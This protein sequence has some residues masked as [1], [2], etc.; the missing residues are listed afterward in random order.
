MAER[1]GRS[2]I[3]ACILVGLGTFLLAVALLIPAYTVGKLK[4]TPLDLEVTTVATGNGDVLDSK[5]LLAG[6]A[7]VN[8]NVPIVAQRYVITEQ[9]SDAEVIS[10]QAGQTVRRTD[11]QGETGLLAATVDRLTADRVSAMPVEPPVGTI[12]TSSLVPAEEVSHTGLQ[13]KWPFDAEK[14]SYP[15][16]DLNTR[17]SNDINFV[18]ETEI[19]GMKVYHYNQTVEP[20][21]LSKVVP[22]DPTNK[23]TLPA[24]TWGVPGE[25]QPITMSRWYTNVRDVWVDPITGVVINGQEQLYQYYARDKAKPEVTVLKVTLPFDENTIE[26]QIGQAKD[27]Q[28][29][30]SLFGRTLPIVA[31]ILGVIALIAGLVI[32]IRGG[33]GKKGAPEGGPENPPNGS[34]QAE[35]HDWTSDKTE[36]FPT[37]NLDQGGF[38]EP[39]RQQ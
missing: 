26:Y 9:P 23:L 21:D 17:Q 10:L 29:K 24:K 15:Y 32:G 22:G 39:P 36:E 20:T 28:D 7:Q 2:R 25:D 3:L 38:T 16:F 14:K 30:L 35:D 1:S 37:V 6:K 33:R 19:N 27:G 5:A 11:K 13:Y 12:Q 4:K 18:E 31:G 8:T 34:G